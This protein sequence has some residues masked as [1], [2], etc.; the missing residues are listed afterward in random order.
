M[1]LHQFLVDYHDF[2]APKLDTYEQAIYL[3][4]FRHSRL[5]GI[6][7][8]CIGFK[9]ARKNMAS[10]IGTRGH[11]M[12]ES[13]CY[14]KL[15]SLVGKGLVERLSTDQRGTRLRLRLPSEVPG[16][17][18]ATADIVP[19]DLEQ[20]DFFGIAAHRPLILE[21]EGHRCFYCTRK[22]D[23][24]NYVIEHVQSRPEGNNSY[25][26]VVA[27]C[28]QCNNRKNSSPADDWLRT[29]Y[30]EGFLDSGEFEERLSHLERLRAGQLKPPM[31]VP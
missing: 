16:L 14:E 19:V 4:I 22:I 12:S 17:I 25:R 7:E 27:A 5:V 2:V 28:R 10:G 20:I 11:A 31:L 29:L 6:E 26:N 21:R 30:R 3:Y 13:T 8:I 9:S 18:P 23:D 24:R 1:D 15:D